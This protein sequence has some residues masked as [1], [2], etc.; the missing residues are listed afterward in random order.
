MEGNPAPAGPV[1]SLTPDGTKVLELVDAAELRQFRTLIE[2]A[3]QLL[4]TAAYDDALG[5]L[6]QLRDRSRALHP[7]PVVEA[8]AG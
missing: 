6:Q 1:L 2:S 7:I 3:Y 5:T 8:V 4:S